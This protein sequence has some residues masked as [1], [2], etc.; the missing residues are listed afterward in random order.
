MFI[1]P[2]TPVCHKTLPLVYDES[3]SY[4]E[5]LCKINEK[6]TEIITLLN[7]LE[8]SWTDYTD[9]EVTKLRNEINARIDELY[10]YVDNNVDI[11]DNKIDDNVILLN[12]K[13]DD[14][15]DTINTKY[16]AEVAKLYN[17]IYESQEMLIDL[18]QTYDR[19]VLNTALEKINEIYAEIER[20]VKEIPVRN[21]YRA[22]FLS[23]IQEYIYDSFEAARSHP[24][25][26]NNYDNA[27]LTCSQFRNLNLTALDYDNHASLYI[28]PYK[29]F[30]P[31]DGRRKFPQE[32]VDEIASYLRVDLSVT[33]AEFEAYN[34]TAAEY[35]AKEITAYDFDWNAKRFLGAA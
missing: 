28:D 31:F 17:T 30:S 10:T 19:V 5:F 23:S 21:P 14:N 25:T 1:T 35:D 9:Q 20:V 29:L 3:L 13:I 11:L 22:G 26:A 33:C 8:D 7:S 18:M 2:I 24:I 15:F 16:D 4:Y 32:I 27:R 6:I 34:L 12:N